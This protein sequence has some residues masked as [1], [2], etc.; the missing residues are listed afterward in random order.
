MS[1]N[2]PFEKIKNV[3]LALC[4]VDMVFPSNRVGYA[5]LIIVN[6]D[7]EVHERPYF[8]LVVLAWVRSVVNA[9]RRPIPHGRIWV[10]QV[11]LY[12]YNR[13]TWLV[14]V[15]HLLPSRKRFCFRKLTAR[16]RF[17]LH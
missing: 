10:L 11:S 6:R 9:Q 15:K 16:T 8:E 5:H 4:I 12:P 13:L 3:L 14:L 7:S 17:L 2:W 1:G